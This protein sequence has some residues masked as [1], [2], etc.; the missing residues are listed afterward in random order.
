MHI[1][2][3]NKARKIFSSEGG[4]SME[5]MG[6]VFGMAGISWGLIAFFIATNAQTNIK[7]LEE[8]LAKLEDSNNG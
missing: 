2:F 8:R 1:H 7:K 3:S 6:F 4:F 5:V